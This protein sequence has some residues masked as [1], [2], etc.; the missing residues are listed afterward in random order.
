MSLHS[1]FKIL[2]RRTY[3]SIF[4]IL[5]RFPVFFFLHVA[6]AILHAAPPWDAFPTS[7]CKASSP[8]ILK[9]DIRFTC[10]FK[11]VGFVKHTITI[12]SHIRCIL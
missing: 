10:L 11:P 1:F 4:E 2:I 9:E 5:H 12:T 3:Y 8:D 6:P 7:A